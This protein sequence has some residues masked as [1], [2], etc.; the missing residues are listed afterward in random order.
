MAL[1]TE[2]GDPT[3]ITATASNGLDM[4]SPIYAKADTVLGN[5]IT[6]IPTRLIVDGMK[7]GV[8]FCHDAPYI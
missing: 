7:R 1:F 5:I 8:P 6:L 3:M 4:I 2:T